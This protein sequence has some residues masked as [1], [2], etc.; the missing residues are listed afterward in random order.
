MKEL[1][2]NF[3][4]IQKNDHKLHEIFENFAYGEVFEYSNLPEKES[5]SDISIITLHANHLKHL[6]RFY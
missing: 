4:R 6:K 5:I 3:G 1:F 2:S